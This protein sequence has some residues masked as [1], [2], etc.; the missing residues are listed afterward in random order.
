[1]LLAVNI[2]MTIIHINNKP[3]LPV[4]IIKDISKLNGMKSHLTQYF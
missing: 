1:M 3:D 4:I 2:I